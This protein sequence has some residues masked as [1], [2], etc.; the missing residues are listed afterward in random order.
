LSTALRP[1]TLPGHFGHGAALAAATALLCWAALWNGYPLVWPDS[2]AYIHP[3]NLVFR[4]V[5]YNFLV[6]PLTWA[7]GALWPIVVF[8]SLIV[9][10]LMRLLLREVFGDGSART[11][12][13]VT[14]ATAVLTALPW[15]TGFVMADVYAPVVVL[16]LFLLAFCAATLSRPERLLLAAILLAACA[17]HLT[18]PLIATGLLALFAGL[19]RIGRGRP[20]WPVPRL[21]EPA[22]PVALSI[23]LL[24]G[25]NAIVHHEARY[26]VGGYAF[27]LARLVADGPAVDYLRETCPVR[28]FAMCDFL[29]QLPRN[30]SRF[31]WSAD[32]PFRKLGGFIGYRSEGREIVDGTL[33]RYPWRIARTAVA[34]GIRQLFKVRTGPRLVS[35]LGDP[36]PTEEI[37]AYFP[38]DFAAYADSRQS[39]GTL[40]IRFLQRLHAVAIAVSWLVCIGLAP[41]LARRGRRL[42]LLL[43]LAIAS[44]YIL[45]A[46]VTA[47]STVDPRYGARVAWMIPF[48]CLACAVSFMQRQRAS[49]S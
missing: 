35:Y 9:A 45:N 34:D 36:W 7:A 22:I 24:V 38:G 27:T 19:R 49:E 30:S 11:F 4:S 25:N 12:L 13:A 40:H 44:G 18:H 48:F 41:L 3:V 6:A 14:L 28:R 42:A 37:R 32:S 17:V 5:F 29:D 47:L 26:S 20:A 39:R 10:Y 8:Q 15:E 16:T 46:F 43:L 21:L 31:L 33:R 1:G 2:G 23:A